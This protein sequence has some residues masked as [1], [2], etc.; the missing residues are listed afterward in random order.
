MSEGVC[1]VLTVMLTVCFGELRVKECV[2]PR[3]LHARGANGEKML[4]I[5]DGLTLSL[6]KSKVFAENFTFTKGDDVNDSNT[7]QLMLS[8]CC[9]LNFKEIEESLY[10]DRKHGSSVV[11]QESNGYVQV[12]GILTDTL[13]IE[14]VLSSQ[15]SKDGIVA[16]RISKL[17]DTSIPV[18]ADYVHYTHLAEREARG[19]IHRVARQRLRNSPETVTVETRILYDDALEEQKGSY[20]NQYLVIVMNKVN[21]LYTALQNPRPH[22]VIVGIEKLLS[23]AHLE[24]TPGRYLKVC[25]TLKPLNHFVYRSWRRDAQDVV[26]FLSGWRSSDERGKGC[27]IICGIC[28]KYKVTVHSVQGLSESTSA[29]FIAHE[30]GH[31][32]G[33]NHEEH[34]GHAGLD[35]GPGAGYVMAAVLDTPGR[36]VFSHCVYDKMK[37]CLIEKDQRCFEKTARMQL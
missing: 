17:N 5:R 8:R 22:F 27:T 29:L 18:Y 21:L 1:F 36:S 23:E 32:L 7:L 31:Q 2:Y 34:P 12:T 6:E 11:V 35:C 14:A 3:I 26:A 9:Q 20:L 19:D 33:M 37:R 15:R 25:N 4:H 28:S 16:H 24:L 10:Q 30:L 13:S